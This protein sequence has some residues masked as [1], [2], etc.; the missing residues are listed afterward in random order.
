MGAFRALAWSDRSF[1]RS[2]FSFEISRIW[3]AVGLM[4]VTSYCYTR[5]RKYMRGKRIY[6]YISDDTAVS[7][8]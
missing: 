4:A 2:F 7:G 8:P 6:E 1:V 5:R 3:F